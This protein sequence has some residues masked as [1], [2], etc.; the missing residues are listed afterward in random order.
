[1]ARRKFKVVELAVSKISVN[2]D[3]QRPLKKNFLRYLSE[4]WDWDL[5]EPIDVVAINNGQEY[6]CIE[7][8]H[9]FATVKAK[10]W[11][12]IP[13]IIRSSVPSEQAAQIFSKK[14]TGRLKMGVPDIFRADFHSGVEYAIDINEI[15]TKHGFSLS[16]FGTAGKNSISCVYAVIDI[17]KKRGKRE[18]LDNT[19]RVI[20]EAW[21]RFPSE[22]LLRGLA[23]LLGHAE[24]QKRFDEKRLL[25]I[26]QRNDPDDLTERCRKRARQERRY[27]GWTTAL[28]IFQLY[29]KKL[30]KRHQVPL[31]EIYEELGY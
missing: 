26:L 7:G 18:R 29:N 14:N 21:D 16:L 19:L 28:L 5:F 27:R 22:I 15:V 8:Q 1:M 6:D 2:E 25:T 3:Y 13:A 20:R 31:D 12:K 4:N 30:P 17:Y 24:G 9:R 11:R 23:C 10:G